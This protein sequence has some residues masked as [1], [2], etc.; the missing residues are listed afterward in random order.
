[1]ALVWSFSVETQ[2]IAFEP[3]RE[4]N[5]RLPHFIKKGQHKP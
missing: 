3:I 5:E 4:A 1:M 2:L